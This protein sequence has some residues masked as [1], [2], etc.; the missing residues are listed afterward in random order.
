MA[1]S[2]EFDQ[3]RQRGVI[4]LDPSSKQRNAFEYPAH[5][6]RQT[7]KNTYTTHEGL[8][9]TLDNNDYESD[10]ID[11]R[12]HSKFLLMY[13]ITENGSIVNNDRLVFKV[14]FSDDQVTWYDYQNGPFG[15]LAEEQS[16]TPCDRSVSG[17]CVGEYVRVT[18]RTD[19]ANANPE[20]NFFSVTCKITI[21]S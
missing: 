9:C 10:A 21:M 20:V 2:S 14:Q 17:D 12:R 19:Y 16:T 15:Y 6:V 3:T 5:F 18:I 13:S 4:I 1:L 8:D 7:Q 11:C